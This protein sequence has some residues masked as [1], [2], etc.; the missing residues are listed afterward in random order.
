[1]AGYQVEYICCPCSDVFQVGFT[2]TSA[3]NHPIHTVKLELYRNT[4]VSLLFSTNL[5]V[6]LLDE[7]LEHQSTSKE[8]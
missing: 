5:L 8:E 3:D 2:E 7:K 1:M 6:K 4:C